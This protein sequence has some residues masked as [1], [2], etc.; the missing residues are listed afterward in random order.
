M[1][2]EEFKKAISSGILVDTRMPVSFSAHIPGS[3]NICLDRLAAFTG[4]INSH[5]KPVYLLLERDT[6]A[7]I[8]SR[9]IHNVAGS[10]SGGFQAWATAGYDIAFMGL[11]V[12]DALAGMLSADK[13]TLLDVRN[14][15]GWKGGRIKEAMHIYVGELEN[16]LGEVPRSLPVVCICS[17]G[18]TAS[19]AASILKRAGFTDVYN[20]LGGIAAWKAKDYPLLYES[21]LEK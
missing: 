15:A 10:L 6:D 19:L 12:P 7:E 13:V 4:W 3:Y 18:L 14:D 17:T 2:P 21:L 8:A 16:R 20:V 9:Q 11:L 5:E 1:Q